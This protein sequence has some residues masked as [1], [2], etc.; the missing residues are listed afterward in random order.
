MILVPLFD[1]KFL[2]EFAAGG[3]GTSKS[4][5][6]GAIITRQGANLSALSGKRKGMIVIASYHP[7]PLT[8]ELVMDDHIYRV[9]EIVGTSQTSIEDAIATAVTRASST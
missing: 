6:L 5:A 4:A 9:I 2:I 3:V 8:R 1:L 7:V